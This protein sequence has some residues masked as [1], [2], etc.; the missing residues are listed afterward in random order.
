MIIEISLFPLLYIPILALLLSIFSCYLYVKMKL[1]NDL[2]MMIGYLL[3]TVISTFLF[4]YINVERLFFWDKPY[5]IASIVVLLTLL[6]M[7]VF[8]EKHPKYRENLFFFILLI[9]V[10]LSYFFTYLIAGTLVTLLFLGYGVYQLYSIKNGNIEEDGIRALLI[11]FIGLFSGIG[12]WLPFESG[13]FFYSVLLLFLLLYEC[14]RYFERMVKL[15]RSAGMNSITDPLTGLFNKGFLLK[16]AE[17]L[18]EEQS[19]SIIFIDIDNFKYLND[20]KGHEHGDRILKQ[21]GAIFKSVI[22]NKGFV[23]RFGGE[24]MVAIVLNG[25]AK[26]LAEQF[27]EQVEKK[28]EVTVSVG[29]A[30]GNG[31]G[32]EIIKLA[33]ENMYKAKHNGKNQVIIS[34]I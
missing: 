12:Q 11:L 25:N 24:E 6:P 17:Q 2:Y 14:L 31:N 23:C 10:F 28:T 34:G 20:T 9:A 8:K 1:K 4:V 19:I 22:N 5:H 15:F 21:V 7:A 29:V 13:G 30:G 16:K 18:A 32:R 26:R 27:R 3:A 33:D